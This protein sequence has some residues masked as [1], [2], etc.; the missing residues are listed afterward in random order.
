MD[1]KELYPGVS[2][3]QPRGKAE[4]GRGGFAQYSKLQTAGIHRVRRWSPV[5]V[6]WM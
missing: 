4:T 2:P 6:P 5:F 1:N 3:A